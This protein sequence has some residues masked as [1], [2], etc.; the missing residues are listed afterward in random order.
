MIQWTAYSG[1]YLHLA[2]IFCKHVNAGFQRRTFARTINFQLATI[3][4]IPRD[5][6]HIL[7]R[8]FTIA[9][10]FPKY[11]SRQF[12][13]IGKTSLSLAAERIWSGLTDKAFIAFNH[14]KLYSYIDWYG[15]DGG[16]VLLTRWCESSSLLPSH[17]DLSTSR[18]HRHPVD[19]PW[20]RAALDGQVGNYSISSLF[21]CAKSAFLCCSTNFLKLKSRRIFSCGALKM[22]P[23]SLCWCFSLSLSSLCN[24]LSLSYCLVVLLSNGV[25]VGLPKWDWSYPDHFS[26]AQVPPFTTHLSQAM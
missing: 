18:W 20:S 9:R 1:W 5:L 24:I 23:T 14:G 8:L 13:V 6:C 21:N 3:W 19:W 4:K 16:Q 2:L 11:F 12:V 10:Q 22:R 26:A 15:R 7:W 17:P 25:D